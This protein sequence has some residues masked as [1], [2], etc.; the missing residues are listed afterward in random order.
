M[1]YIP[2]IFTT[3]LPFVPNGIFSAYIETDYAVALAFLI[4]I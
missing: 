1:S 3:I 2:I 4:Y